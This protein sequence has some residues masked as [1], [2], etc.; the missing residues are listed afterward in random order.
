ML[1]FLAMRWLAL[2][3]VVLSVALSAM[4]GCGDDAATVDA[5]LVNDASDEVFAT[6]ED[7][8]AQ[9]GLMS[10]PTRAAT[11]VAPTTGTSLTK[12]TPPTFTW[13]LPASTRTPRHG[14]A[15]GTFFWLQFTG[16]GISDKVDV[17]AVGVMSWTPSAD[18][19]ARIAVSPGNLS[20]RLVTA[21][22]ADALV[23]EGPWEADA[24]PSYPVTE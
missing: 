16:A 1:A 22:V 6:L 19:W 20:V 18:D 4:V 7:E 11:I 5:I 3:S 9:G 17:L 23:V 12:G 24:S 21:V 8:E 10:D 15:N 14:V 2:S 13:A